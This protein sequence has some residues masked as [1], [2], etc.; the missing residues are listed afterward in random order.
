MVLVL[1]M[2]YNFITDF[3]CSITGALKMYF[4]RHLCTFSLYNI[5]IVLLQFTPNSAK[6][7]IF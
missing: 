6:K 4:Q 7:K 2:V 3:T 5:T 1:F